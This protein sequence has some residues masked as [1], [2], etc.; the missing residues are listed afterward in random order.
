MNLIFWA[1]KNK[2]NKKNEIPIYCRITI[3]GE[4]AEFSTGIKCKES[5]WDNKKY[6]IKGQS[7]YAINANRKFDQL[8]QKL[9]SIYYELLFNND[10]EPSANEVKSLLDV[11]R[12]KILYFVDLLYEYA[13]ELHKM[14]C[15]YDRLK[16]HERFIDAIKKTLLISGDSH[17]RLTKCDTLFFDKL[18]FN[19][20]NKQGYSVGYAKKLT[21]YIKASFRFGFNRRY[22]EQNFAENYKFPYREEREFV[23]LDEWEVDKITNYQFSEAL[24]RTADLFCVQC[25][26]GL[27]YV[28]LKNLNTSHLVRDNDGSMWINITRQKVKTAECVI[29]VI[30]RVFNILKKYDFKLP[31]VSNQKYNDALKKIASEVGINKRLTS[32]VGRKTY[33][34]LLLNKDVPIE[35]VSKL[36][37]HSDIYVTQKHYAKVLHMKVAKDVRAV[38]I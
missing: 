10:I 33:G 19:L 31:V 16:L 38:L 23:Y 21:R 7:E 2:T 6:R 24:Q 11:K 35:T 8:S 13:W 17:I 5:E 14:Y 28:D 29:P 30:K 9:T 37:G 4:R 25:Y 22:L 15:N 1:V 26:T 12:K 27:A 20:V 36:L 3:G 18:V 32:H 34:T